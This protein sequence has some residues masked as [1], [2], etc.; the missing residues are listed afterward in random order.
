MVISV[1]TE[2]YAQYSTNQT[3]VVESLTKSLDKLFQ[4]IFLKTTIG[5]NNIPVVMQDPVSELLAGTEESAILRKIED[6]SQYDKYFALPKG[7]DE[8]LLPD[9]NVHQTVALMNRIVDKD[10]KLIEK[11]SHE[12]FDKGTVEKTTKYIFD[13]IFKYLKYNLEEGEQLRNPLVTYHLGQRKAIEHFKKT[14]QF[15]QAYSVDCDDISIF[16]ACILKNLNISYAFKIAGYGMYGTGGYGHVYAIANPNFANPIII[17]PVYH[18]YNAEKTPTIMKTYPSS[19][20]ALAGIPVH[21]LSGLDDSVS[22]S[23]SLYQFLIESRNAIANNPQLVT[24]AHPD[25]L[26]GLYDYLIEHWNKTTRDEALQIVAQK[27]EELIA[28]G[29]ILTY[30][31][32]G[33]D[34]LGFFGELGKIRICK[35]IRKKAKREECFK[36]KAADKLAKEEAKKN[37]TKDNGKKWWQNIMPNAKDA[38]TNLVDKNYANETVT[39]DTNTTTNTTEDKPD[40]KDHSTMTM[41]KT[42]VSDNKIPLAIGG[43]ALIGGVLVFIN[44]DKIFK[45]EQ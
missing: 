30:S 43:V 10:Y 2:A 7:T 28:Q 8:I 23:D 9:G 20:K 14:G 21:Y 15:I 1:I 26:I 6:G 27:E 29:S 34:G 22:I 24:V 13:W 33:Y 31:L 3:P 39:T 25:T 44:K 37:G 4:G 17:D 42:F 38:L 19:Y 5:I 40:V 35:L 16:I 12:I 18:K 11:A 36:N 45:N 41:V 32:Q